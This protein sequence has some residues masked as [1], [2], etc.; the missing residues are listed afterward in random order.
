MPLRVEIIWM[1]LFPHSGI[2]LG[3]TKQ[4]EPHE[5][6]ADVKP[7][8][9]PTTSIG[10]STRT[11]KVG[12]CH[13]GTPQPFSPFVFAIIL[14]DYL[15]AADLVAFKLRSDALIFT[16]IWHKLLQ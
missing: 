1:K 12:C 2:S 5:Y 8:S 4:E 14:Y 7:Q 16:V 9:V 3:V 11:D 13:P 10:Q 15:K 6:D